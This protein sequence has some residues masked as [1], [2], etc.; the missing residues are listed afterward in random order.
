MGLPA[1]KL[2]RRYNYGDYRTWPDDERWELLDGVAWN[3]SPAPNRRHQYVTGRLF[4]KISMFLEGKPCRVYIAPFDVLLPDTQDQDDD[5]V[6][7]V[8]QPDV[9]VFCGSDRLTERGA[10]GAP[11]L[12]VEVITPWTHQKDMNEKLSLYE[13][14]GVREF[15]L[16]DPG[17]RSVLIFRSGPDKR[18]GEAEVRTIPGRL[19]S[20]VLDGFV[21]ELADLFREE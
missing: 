13:R 1:R 7:T 3:M 15:W 5:E 2:D 17:N 14:H 19:D 4:A 12:V 20:R 11:D 21:L 10:R 9:S 8:V 16:V 18:Y 6:S